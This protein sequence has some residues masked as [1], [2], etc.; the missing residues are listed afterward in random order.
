[1]A[2]KQEG[3][4]YVV[5]AGSLKDNGGTSSNNGY[6]KTIAEA[7]SIIYHKARVHQVWHIDTIDGERIAGGVS[8]AEKEFLALIEKYDQKYIEA[9]IAPV[10]EKVAYTPATIVEEFNIIMIRSIHNFTLG[11][12]VES[13]EELKTFCDK[14]IK[15]DKNL[16][17]TALK[18]LV[19]WIGI[20]KEEG[21]EVEGYNFEETE[22]G[23]NVRKDNA[24][25]FSWTYYSKYPIEGFGSVEIQHPDCSNFYN[26][27]CDLA[28]KNGDSI[29]YF[30]SN[31]AKPSDIFVFALR[32]DGVL[33]ENNGQKS[34]CADHYDADFFKGTDDENKAAA[35][36]Y[37]NYLVEFLSHFEKTAEGY[38][39][40]QD[41][42][43]EYIYGD[44]DKTTETTEEP[45]E[46]KNTKTTF[47]E[48]ER[49]I[50]VSYRTGKNGNVR[51]I[52]YIYRQGTHSYNSGFFTADSF[53]AKKILEENG[54]TVKEFVVADKAATRERGK[55]KFENALR[56]GRNLKKCSTIEEQSARFDI[57]AEDAENI[58]K[59]LGVD[60]NGVK[61]E[62]NEKSV[63]DEMIK[64]VEKA[65][66]L[67]DNESKCSEG[68]NL[69]KGNDERLKNDLNANQAKFE[70]GKYYYLESFGS[71]TVYKVLKRSENKMSTS[72][73]LQ[74]YLYIDTEGKEH[75]MRG[76]IGTFK[77]SIW[78]NTCE[79]VKLDKRIHLWTYSVYQ[80]ATNEIPV[81]ENIESVETKKTKKSY[82]VLTETDTDDV[83]NKVLIHP[84]KAGNF[85]FEF[86][87]T[88]ANLETAY[89]RFARGFNQAVAD[90][91]ISQAVIDF[92]NGYAHFDELSA[93]DYDGLT[94]EELPMWGDCGEYYLGFDS[95]EDRHYIWL[96][97]HAKKSE[98]AE[99]VKPEE[100]QPIN[101]TFYTTTEEKARE[102]VKPFENYYDVKIEVKN[103]DYDLTGFTGKLLAR[104]GEFYALYLSNKFRYQTLRIYN[105]N[106]VSNAT[107]TKSFTEKQVTGIAKYLGLKFK[108][109]EDLAKME[110]AYRVEIEVEN[111]GEQIKRETKYAKTFEDVISICK[112]T[113]AKLTTY[114]IEK[115]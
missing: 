103:L 58:C 59:M 82:K 67:P 9:E 33:K 72:V 43:R 61:I 65:A 89:N 69:S 2:A 35:F 90:G 101:Q 60:F 55:I 8:L 20:A 75:E 38:I 17:E 49:K 48:L 7:V 99:E 113:G 51:K 87:T 23:W 84:E 42:L 53:D 62:T 98:P 11:N 104:K 66:N 77:I 71:K 24:A 10:S 63:E 5:F 31:V 47:E 96:I 28:R 46:E 15:Q 108:T 105:A 70:I 16:F 3:F 81:E 91:V 29:N 45:A 34:F 27:R 107:I 25:T 83:I 4:K 110:Y 18:E 12:Y 6:T 30:L 92:Y 26:V 115:S 56:Y 37:A 114:H 95:F 22:N 109:Q 80:A 79:E 100:V 68:T 40:N 44:S 73:T 64:T 36:A 52:W 74:E 54:W 97:V 21:I 85:E 86:M 93:D 13:I 94:C 76:D 111:D 50:Q 78:R 19:E 32:V 39:L 41:Y 14:A 112:Y 57:T 102:I 88:C 1:M 106:I